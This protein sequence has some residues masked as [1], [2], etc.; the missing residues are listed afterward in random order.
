MKLVIKDLSFER[1]NQLLFDRLNYELLAGECLQVH[2][3][4][5]SGKS[6]LL[7]MLA[8]FIEPQQGKIVWGKNSKIHYMGHQNAGKPYL[9]VYENLQLS[10]I[11]TTQQLVAPTHLQN[12]LT[13]VG[14][15]R[16]IH[17]EVRYLSAGQMRRLSLAKLLL[18]PLATW[19]LDEP[20]TTLDAAGQQLLVTLLNQHLASGETVII[21]THQ[22][23][24]LQVP[25]KTIQLG[26]Q[27]A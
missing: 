8:G 23:L 15:T 27:Y 2:G 4:N 7:R 25:I 11:L 22:N 26:E 1:N 14:L 16:M 12:A 17:S 10:E 9:T 19:I 21:A 18:E 13:T 6:T 24:S 3:P 5:G 20:T